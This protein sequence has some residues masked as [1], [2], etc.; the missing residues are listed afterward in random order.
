MASGTLEGLVYHVT[1]TGRVTGDAVFVGTLVGDLKECVG[2][3]GHRANLV[4]VIYRAPD[5]VLWAAANRLFMRTETAWRC[6]PLAGPDVSFEVTAMTAASGGGLSLGT[7]H[8][9]LWRYRTD[10]SVTRTGGA[11][12]QRVTVLLEL[13]DGTVWTGGDGGLVRFRGGQVLEVRQ[14]Q[15]LPRGGAYT[16]LTGSGVNLWVFGPRGLAIVRDGRVVAPAAIDRIPSAGCWSAVRDGADI[17]FNCQGAWLLKIASQRIGRGRAARGLSIR[18]STSC[19]KPQMICGRR[20]SRGRRA[21]NHEV[22]RWPYLVPDTKGPRVFR[23]ADVSDRPRCHLTSEIDVGSNSEPYASMSDRLPTLQ[24]LSERRLEVVVYGRQPGSARAAAVPLSARWS[25]PGVERDTRP[26]R[27]VQQPV[28][29]RLS[30]FGSWPRTDLGVWSDREATWSFSIAPHWYKRW[31]VRLVVSSSLVAVSGLACHQGRVCQAGRATLKR[32]FSVQLERADP[33][34]RRVAR[35]AAAGVSGRDTAT[36]FAGHEARAR[37]GP[38]EA[39]LDAV[40]SELQGVL[41]DGRKA[42]WAIRE[43]TIIRPRPED[44]VPSRR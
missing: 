32:E 40:L 5:G 30:A 6:I 26:I 36:A 28:R 35:Y 1:R 17:W 9:E 11:V 18:R 10:G 34:R 13:E 42:I 14:A 16:V 3:A 39:R 41:D 4:N 23:S 31:W 44:C 21:L 8:G 27:V 20:R 33:H 2:P 43:S 37:I 12:R 29:G 19:S 15:G 38:N 22:R 25:R 24:P 7:S